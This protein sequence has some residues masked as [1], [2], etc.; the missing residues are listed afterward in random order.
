MRIVG[1]L[2]HVACALIVLLLAGV[3]AACSSESSNESS[4]AGSAGGNAG[5]A[6][7][8]RN[9]AAPQ[10]PA[11]RS[12]RDGG[13]RTDTKVPLP[14][15]RSVVYTATLRVRADNVDASATKAKQQVAAA[16]GYIEHETG[17]SSPPSATLR[18][19]VPADRYADLLTRLSTDLGTKRS[20][21][22]QAEDVTGEVAD[23]DSRVRSAQAALASFRKLLDRAKTVGEVINIEQ[24]I[25]SREADLESLQARQKSLQESTRYATLTV[26]LEARSQAAKEKDD[27]RGGFVGGL[28]NGW[29]AFTAFVGGVATVLGWLLP[30]LVTAAVI[31][32]PALAV[33]R[34]LRDRRPTPSPSP[35]GEVDGA[36]QEERKMTTVDSAPSSS[37]EELPPHGPPPPR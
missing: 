24:E 3:L 29:D 20:L 8:A 14:A 26:E 35:S 7:G 13:G 11:Y 12:P 36:Q 1:N 4:T 37:S 30:F 31:G 27:S 34:R 2:R 22:Q 28:Q 21:S 10:A 17:S 5:D 33:W 15:T 16:G 18:L 32:L 9:G 6:A 19:K 25:A 23:V